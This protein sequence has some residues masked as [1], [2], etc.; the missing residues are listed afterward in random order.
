MTDYVK[1]G[2][3]AVVVAAVYLVGYKHAESEGEAVLESLKSQYA[4]AIINAQ[5]EGKAKYEK[6]IKGLIADLDRARSE[7]DSRM[8]E[9]E[10]FR[11]RATDYGTCRRQR[12]D[13]ARIAVG[14]EGVASRAIVYLE[15]GR[16]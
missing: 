2:A 15:G 13:L 10:G 11:A 6:T 1:Y 9:L 8:L 16:K 14:L 4:Q 5:E 7:R 12:D 3:I